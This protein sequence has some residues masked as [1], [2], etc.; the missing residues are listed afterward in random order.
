MSSDKKSQHNPSAETIPYT[1]SVDPT[2]FEIP[3]RV[4]NPGDPVNFHSNDEVPV[5]V[6]I[7]RG[8]FTSS[9]PSV[10]LERGT[11]SKTFTVASQPEPGAVTPYTICAPMEGGPEGGM[12]G[13]IRVGGGDDKTP[14]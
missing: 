12:T 7:P 2:R 5:T 3:D 6:T 11:T 14:R 13:T 8:L 10:R 1:V 4:F 9:D